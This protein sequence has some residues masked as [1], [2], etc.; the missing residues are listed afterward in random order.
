MRAL[1]PPRTDWR[2]DLEGLR[3][4]AI[5]LV[6]VYHVWF[7][8][9]SGGVDIFLLLSGYFVGGS[10]WRR[11]SSDRPPSAGSYALRHMRRLLPAS[12]VVLLATLIG[13]VFVLP[14]TRWSGSAVESIA[15][16]TYWENW[17]FIATSGEYGGVDA[18]QSPWQ[19]FWSL[20]VQGQLFVLLPILLWLIWRVCRFVDVQSRKRY[21][22]ATI[23]MLAIASFVYACALTASDQPV[24]YFNTFARAW[25]FLGGTLIA[26][27]LARWQPHG[28]LWQWATWPALLVILTFGAVVPAGSLFPGPITVVPLAAAVVLII[29]GSLTSE[30]R[31]PITNLLASRWVA[32]LG[33]YAYAFYLWHWPILVLFVAYAGYVPGL[34]SGAM[35][36]AM[37]AC[38]AVATHHLVEVPLRDAPNQSGEEASSSKALRRSSTAF[39]TVASI[40]VVAVPAA[41]IVQANLDRAQYEA[42][43]TALGEDFDRYPGALSHLAPDRYGDVASLPPIPSVEVATTDLSQ[44]YTDEC[45]TLEQAIDLK[46]C[47][48]NFGSN[49]RVAVF[50][51][52]HVE[53][54]FE[55]YAAV[56]ESE[57]WTLVPV[58]KRACPPTTPEHARPESSCQ[59]W[60]GDAYDYLESG[61]FDLIITDGTYPDGI[62][63]DEVPAG[64]S[65]M[66]ERVSEYAPVLA[67]RDTARIPFDMLDCFAASKD[68]ET[69]LYSRISDQ[70]PTDVINL[71]GV[72]FLDVN[73]LICP[74]AVC[75]PVVG[76]RVV[77]RDSSHFTRTFV[78]SLVPDFSVRIR[79]TLSESDF[80]R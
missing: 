35:I 38:L 10:L 42:S 70:D 46:E 57:G 39:V 27:L 31:R 9:V 24:A 76:N 75:S 32:P 50:G 77:Y 17:Y 48:Y 71:R 4:I 72:H 8:R 62:G 3:V 65:A 14:V 61:N 53:H 52:S 34:R 74:D 43:V 68:C 23:V 33:K 67:V 47:E 45:V 25:E 21:I 55:V 13:V 64:F 66:F 7:G 26:M 69:P 49:A 1:A 29:A 19:H 6:A 54:F 18:E 56:A 16:L 51:A 73:D 12:I 60:L 2:R 36:L 28:K 44:V 20:S 59:A 11:F 63:G 5:V 79:E 22:A 30:R 40:A 80:H 58:L 15:S 37:S 41:W 78:L